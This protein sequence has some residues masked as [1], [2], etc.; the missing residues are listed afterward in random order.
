MEKLDLLIHIAHWA[1][2]GLCLW[3]SYLVFR[4][5]A[6]VSQFWLETK[7]QV[8]MSTWYR[9]HVYLLLSILAMAA[10]AYT[11]LVY[12]VGNLYLTVGIIAITVLQIL[13]GYFNPGWMMRSAQHSSE[14]VSVKEAEDFIPK[15]YEV[16]V[17]EKDGAARAH[18]DYELWRPHIVGNE[19]GLNGENVVMTYCAL[20]NLGMAYKPEIE[21]KPVNLKVM[22]QIENN[23]IMWDTHSGEP[24]QQ[25][26]GRYECSGEQGPQMPQYPVFKMP[27]SA[28][29]KAYPNGQVFKRRRVLM[30]EN[31]LVALYDK[32][33]EALFYMA[34]HRQ[35]QEAEP[36]FP[37]LKHKDNRLHPK[38]PVWGFN[39]GDDYV[40]YSADFVRAQ[41]NLINTVVGDKQIVVHW[42]E[43]Y[44][45]LGIWYSDEPVSEIDFFGNSNCG[46]LQRV[47]TVKA[48]CFY[49]MWY[50]FFPSTDV[51]R[52]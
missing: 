21:G 7:R 42:S 22:S 16:L 33:W 13:A 46:Q 34:I 31:P 25:L 47:E 27:F 19:E 28:F 37:T 29:A 23:L 2:L 8:V 11:H 5:L 4:D 35:K 20:T 10:A 51:N 3:P 40:C 39:V 1:A 41:G 9:R 14:F 43:E 48:G 30:K 15:D 45:S 6:D 24:I 26:W 32:F 18:T 50:N 49:A 52:Q 36:V 44:Q 38:L 17:I 12:S